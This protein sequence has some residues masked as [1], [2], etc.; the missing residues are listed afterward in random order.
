MPRLSQVGALPGLKPEAV[1][2]DIPCS[3]SPWRGRIAN[4]A[5][6]N[7]DIWMSRIPQIYA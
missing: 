5:A 4:A 6:L 1:G 3:D 2:A 7:S